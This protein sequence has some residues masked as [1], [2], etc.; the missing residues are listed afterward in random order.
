M[1]TSSL[2]ERLP[3]M[4]DQISDIVATKGLLTDEEFFQHLQKR[5]VDC[6]FLEVQAVA[7]LLL[8]VTEGTISTRRH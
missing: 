6:T 8:G 2:K 5:N 1:Q 3:F 7:G 4:I